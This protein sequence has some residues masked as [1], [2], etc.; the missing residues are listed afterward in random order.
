MFIVHFPGKGKIKRN[1]DTFKKPVF[2]VEA[3]KINTVLEFY[4]A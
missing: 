2:M 3:G 1:P 4:D